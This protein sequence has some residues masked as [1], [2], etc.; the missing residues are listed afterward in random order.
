MGWREEKDAG[1]RK[2][3]R[4]I[5]REGCRECAGCR[6]GRTEGGREGGEK[7]RVRDKLTHMNC[8]CSHTHAHTP[9]THLNSELY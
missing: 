1:R 9:H 2:R 6:E 7:E 5:G 8:T 3:W 4:V